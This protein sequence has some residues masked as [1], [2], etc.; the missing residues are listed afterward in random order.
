VDTRK[1]QN[2]WRESGD[3]EG[4]TDSVSVAGRRFELVARCPVGGS[5][6]AWVRATSA[7][8]PGATLMRPLLVDGRPVRNIAEFAGG[9][10]STGP[11]APAALQTLA[12]VIRT[13]VG[14]ATEIEPGQD[15][16]P[17]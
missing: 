10:H 6:V 17:T 14:A 16:C 2:A 8:G 4:T 13:A 12:E 15:L 9:I 7:D 3:N 11:T 1:R 5:W